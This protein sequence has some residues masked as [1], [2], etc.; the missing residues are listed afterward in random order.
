[1]LLFQNHMSFILVRNTKRD[2]RRHMT[3]SVTA[4]FHYVEKDAMKETGPN[5]SFYVPPKKKKKQVKRDLEAHN[6]IS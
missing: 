4:H 5:I 3:T 6:N 2:D 1:M